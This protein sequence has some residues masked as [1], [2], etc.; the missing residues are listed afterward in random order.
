[1]VGE[2]SDAIAFAVGIAGNGREIGVQVVLHSEVEHRIAV[3]G[4]EDN[5]DDD[6]R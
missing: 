4:A 5:V 3:S 2:A 6:E 1:M